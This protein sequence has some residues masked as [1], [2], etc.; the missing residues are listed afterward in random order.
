METEARAKKWTVKEAREKQRYRYIKYLAELRNLSVADLHKVFITEEKKQARATC[1][2]SVFYRVCQGKRKSQRIMR[3]IS[4]LLK[5]P[6]RELW[7]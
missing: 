3:G 4:R 5:A 2:Y 7:A 6:Y 1:H